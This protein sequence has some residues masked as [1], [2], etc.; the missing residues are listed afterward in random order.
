[1]DS[2]AIGRRNFD[3]RFV[4]AT[5]TTPVGHLQRMKMQFAKKSLESSRK[6]VNEVMYDVGYSDHKAFREVFKRITGLSPVEYRNKYNK[7][8]AV[9]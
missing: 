1:M 7:E 5:S 6:T 4:K 3:R 8:A 2:L 9:M